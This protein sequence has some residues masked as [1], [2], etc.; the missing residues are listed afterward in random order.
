MKK[1]PGA[2]CNQG[3]SVPWHRR[4]SSSDTCQVLG[5]DSSDT[6]R[7]LELSPQKKHTDCILLKL[8]KAL[9]AWTTV[10]ARFKP[11]REHLQTHQSAL[12][13]WIHPSLS[14]T[15]S[16]AQPKIQRSSNLTLARRATQPHTHPL[17]LLYY[18]LPHDTAWCRKIPCDLHQQ[19][20][21]RLQFCFK[22]DLDQSLYTQPYC[23]VN[24][25]WNQL[26]IIQ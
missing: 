4:L 1:L 21:T 9:Q 3:K 25:L 26:K 6:L 24:R 14:Y 8:H 12:V 19:Q 16:L 2:Y 23:S 7:N 15:G 13:Q 11:P 20:A 22:T 18:T 17:Q 5:I 10:A